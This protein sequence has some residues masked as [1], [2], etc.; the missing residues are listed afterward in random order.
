MGSSE[1]EDSALSD[2]DRD[3]AEGF[4]Y[5]NDTEDD[6]GEYDDDDEEEEEEEEEGEDDSAEDYSDDDEEGS[7]G[8]KPG[9]YHPV[10]V[11]EVYHRRYLVLRKLGWGHFSTVWLVRDAKT[12]NIHALKVQKSAEHYTEAAYDE[13]ELLK[14]T[15]RGKWAKS[16]DLRSRSNRVVR[17][18]DSFE[19]N[20]PHG[21]HVCM[22]FEALGENLLSLIKRYNYAGIPLH[23]VKEI[24][25]KVAE[26]LDY[27]HRGCHIIH[28]DLKPENI[29]LER[30]MRGPYNPEL[31]AHTRDSQPVTPESKVEIDDACSSKSNV[32]TTP[33]APTS[34]NQQNSFE[35]AD[36]PGTDHNNGAEGQNTNTTGTNDLNQASE[37]EHVRP[38]PPPGLNSEDLRRSKKREKKKRQRANKKKRQQE[39]K[40]KLNAANAEAI[41]ATPVAAVARQGDGSKGVSV[42]KRAAGTANQD[43]HEIPPPPPVAP[44]LAPCP[45]HI[46]QN[47]VTRVTTNPLTD[48]LYAPNLTEHVP[49]VPTF[50]KEWNLE[51]LSPDD[52]SPPQAEDGAFVSVVT[53][54]AKL[55]KAFGMPLET[56]LSKGINESAAS[57]SELV[58]EKNPL[59]MRWMLRIRRRIMPGDGGAEA[60]PVVGV[61]AIMGGNLLDASEDSEEAQSAPD[62]LRSLEFN[63]SGSPHNDEDSGEDSS[64]GGTQGE[65]ATVSDIDK[66]QQWHD[67]ARERRWRIL[68]PW[69]QVL[70]VL[71][72][73]ES[74]VDQL[75]FL[76]CAKLPESCKNATLVNLAERFQSGFGALCSLSADFGAIQGVSLEPDVPLL[77]KGI[78][79]FFNKTKLAASEAKGASQERDIP[80]GQ[81]NE[82]DDKA[83]TRGRDVSQR[84]LLLPLANRLS[85]WPGIGAPNS[86]ANNPEIMDGSN[87]TQ[88]H[89]AVLPSDIKS[90]GEEKTQTQDNGVPNHE[91]SNKGKTAALANPRKV[92]G[93]KIVDLGNACWTHKHFAQDIQTRQYRC[94]EVIVGAKY[95][96]SAD[97]W[98]YAC[99]LFE[100]ATGDLLFDPRS[101]ETGSYSRDEDHLAQ[102][103][104]LLG[105][106]PKKV[107]L[108]GRYSQQFF[109]KNGTLRNIKNLKKWGLQSVLEEKYRMSKEDAA[110]L[111]S[112]LLPCLATNP[113]KRATAKEC[114]LH[115]WLN[116]IEKPD[117]GGAH[118]AG[119][120]STQ[121]KPPPLPDENTLARSN[122]EPPAAPSVPVSILGGLVPPSS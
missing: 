111:A 26:G 83:E 2:A 49:M 33:S 86:F 121:D 21:K 72:C 79:I 84:A 12:G 116:S 109:R 89:S 66:S 88:K 75:V 70:A 60:S 47:A 120:G 59:P 27:L 117:P 101:S 4:D 58:D 8:Y 30:P 95:D 34:D 48:C 122:F 32:A 51:Y 91:A 65:H 64:E 50:D 45:P 41:G 53:S 119:A 115:P 38:K 67:D 61:V 87:E 44:P 105:S 110:G 5:Y 31:F 56:S 19:H 9:G 17:L 63:V 40:M 62:L 102:M 13:I 106:I 29:L 43:H 93:I 99:L 39:K 107:A 71:G 100:L 36:Q 54:S 55:V 90:S 22:V 57:N 15:R 114:L 24:A 18:L 118:A 1:E 16:R 103:I 97:I 76:R 68:F 78:E 69:E 7:D 46:N 74:K 3:A 23:K 28:T 81:D 98:S 80:S 113:K 52:W 112:F 20:G 14:A 35:S 10:K 92:G 37:Q 104:E 73:L 25:L 94:P 42:E 96:T 82:G 108:S 85:G 6:Y 77:D 11:G